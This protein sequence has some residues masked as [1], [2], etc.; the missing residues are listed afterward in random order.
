M[1]LRR[2]RVLRLFLA[3]GA[4]L[5]A[6]LL[7]LCERWL[8]ARVV[9]AIRSHRYPGAVRPLDEAEIRQPGRWM[10]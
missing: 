1:A 5:A 2:R 3:A 10:G 7:P 4:T 6:P 9:Q 8:P